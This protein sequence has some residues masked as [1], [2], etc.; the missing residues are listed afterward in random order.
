MTGI[1]ISLLGTT[2]AVGG[3]LV[4]RIWGAT[5]K[6]TGNECKLKHDGLAGLLDS[7]FSNVI[8]RL[9]RIENA[10]KNKGGGNDSRRLS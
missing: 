10:V 9:T 1:E 4:G 3:L 5:N 8:E 7:K 2:V 6:V